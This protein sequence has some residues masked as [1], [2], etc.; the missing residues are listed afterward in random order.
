MERRRLGNTGLDVSVLAFGGAE[1]GYENAPQ[2]SVDRLL[3]GALDAGVNVIDTAECYV[4]S[5]DKIGKALSDRRSE[6]YL[7]TKCGHSSGLD[8]PD[9]TR[10]LVR[11]SIDRSLQRLRTGYID[12]VQLHSC[13]VD[14]LERGDVIEALQHARAAGKT[15][16]IGYSGDGVDALAAIRT[17]AFDTL[18]T[19]V[20]IAD[21]EAIDR[22]VPEAIRKGM[23]VVSKRSLANAVWKHA[24][25]PPDSYVHEYWDRLRVLDYPFLRG[26]PFADSLRTAVRF[27]LSVPGIAAAIVG[28]KSEQ[29]F[30][31]NLA[32]VP[33]SR[34]TPEEFDAIR[35]VWKARALPSWTGQV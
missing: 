28:S 27:T 16:F 1:I 20:N 2:S 17:G 35:T 21:Q 3:G 12:L 25:R 18:Q 24:E 15:R 34:L 33:P 8:E 13:G 19:S 14:V 32:F 31:E 10:E 6:F 4:D 26:L 30:R 7:F 22:T 9:W 23:G 29:R 5:E 11:K